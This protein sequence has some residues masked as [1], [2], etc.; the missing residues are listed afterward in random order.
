MAVMAAGLVL[1]LA[2]ACGGGG[3]PGEQT[4]DPNGGNRP[5]ATPRGPAAAELCSPDPVDGAHEAHMT[6][7][8][9]WTPSEFTIAVGDSITWFNDTT[10]PH[11]VT[12][13][14][15]P[16]CGYV[17]GGKS[18]TVTFDTPGIF[19]FVCR[20]YPTYMSGTVTVQ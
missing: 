13:S 3:T 7:T 10:A 18:A 8:H 15:G 5:S 6:G 12:F 4:P 14:T 20:I 16:D 2:T 17:L 1:V 19:N 11:T 9:E